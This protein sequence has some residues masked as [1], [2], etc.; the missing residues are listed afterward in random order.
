MENEEKKLKEK[1]S[2]KKDECCKECE[3]E[4]CK[5]DCKDCKDGC[6]KECKCD[7]KDVKDECCKD[8]KCDGK[9]CKCCCCKNGKCDSEKCKNELSKEKEEKLILL[10]EFLNYKKRTE[11][12]KGDLKVVANNLLLKQII[13]VVDDFDRAIKLIDKQGEKYLEGVLLIQKKLSSIIDQYGLKVLDIKPGD[14]FSPES[15]ESVS[16]IKVEKEEQNNKVIEV[17][18]KGYVRKDGGAT[19]KSAVVIIGKK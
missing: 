14:I 2:M 5:C 6:C 10:A 8:C 9:D 15:M 11:N 13:E 17:V 3:G 1:D 7:D 12:E 4:E 19:F 16:S 18:Q